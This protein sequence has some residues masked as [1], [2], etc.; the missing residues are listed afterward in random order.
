MTSAVTV[1]FA[2]TVTFSCAHRYFDPRL[3]DVANRRLYGSLYREEGFG[4]NFLLEAHF[5]G[6][7]DPLTGMI[8]NL[9]DVDRW[10][11]SV[12]SIL[13][14]KHLNVLP[15]FRDASP[16]PERIAQWFFSEL[17]PL[18]GAHVTELR[19]RGDTRQVSLAKVRL[20]E[21]ENLWVDYGRP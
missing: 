14:H 3:D 20:H 7:I 5:E 17:E 8:V 10:L 2:R 4:H 9:V 12:A 16:T 19:S 1:R 6:E 15:Q 13:D 18:V 21:G 11:K